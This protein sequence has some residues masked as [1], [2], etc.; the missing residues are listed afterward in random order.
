MADQI[1]ARFA[2]SPSLG[3]VFPEDPNLTGWSLDRDLAV[4]LAAK[5]DPGMVVPPSID[6]PIG[7][8]FWMRPP[9]LAPLFDLGLDWPD[10]PPE[11]VPID[12]TMLHAIERL[13]P[14]ICTHRGFSFET[15]HVPGVGR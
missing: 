12:G 11:P 7:T 9:A 4:G 1:L 5:M 8:M 6:F 2:T 14:V 3:L 15:T 13:L 10:Y